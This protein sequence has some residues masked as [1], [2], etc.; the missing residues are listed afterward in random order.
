MK[1]QNGSFA[2]DGEVDSKNQPHGYGKIIWANGDS[3][4]GQFKNGQLDGFGE[5]RWIDGSYQKGEFKNGE[6]HG[7][8][9]WVDDT[10]ICFGIFENGILLDYIDEDEYEDRLRELA[11][12]GTSNVSNGSAGAKKSVSSSQNDIKNGQKTN[13]SPAFSQNNGQKGASSV[14]NG[15]NGSSAKNSEIEKAYNEG[16]RQGKADRDKELDSET[17]FILGRAEGRTLG[18]KSGYKK[19]YDE[20]YEKGKNDEKQSHSGGKTYID[21]RIEGR[22]LGEADGYKKGYDEGYEK[23]KKEFSSG[24][25]KDLGFANIMKDLAE[26]EGYKKG[27]DEGYKKGRA[28]VPSSSY[29]GGTSSYSSSNSTTSSKKRNGPNG[30]ADKD[31]HDPCLNY[32]PDGKVA[33]FKSIYTYKGEYFYDPVGIYGGYNNVPNGRGKYYD[34]NGN[35]VIDGFFVNGAQEGYG[36]KK[37]EDGSIYEGYFSDGQKHG[38]GRLVEKDGTVTE[39][40]FVKGK[41]DHGYI[42]QWLKDG[43]VFEGYIAFDFH[44]WDKGR[45]K[46]P[47]GGVFE[48]EIGHYPYE[49]WAKGTYKIGSKT[50][51]GYWS[52]DFIASKVTLTE[53]GRKTEIK[54]GKI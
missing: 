52:G 23:A 8:S 53:Y 43:T 11:R 19:G 31:A 44:A 3:Y 20:G 18:E 47:N 2:Y 7:I 34:D 14:S 24:G 15:Q 29:S 17:K 6:A 45:I 48:G 35:V 54:P 4:V 9:K 49:G 25:S 1:I 39:G 5:M 13:T 30:L 10:E 51:E 41:L 16:Y 40:I 42:T 21:G 28:S 38:L 37:D 46:Y 22:K 32:K 33:S 12:S 36:W 26:K 50:Y 27:Y